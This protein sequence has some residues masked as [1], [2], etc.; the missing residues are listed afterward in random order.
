MPEITE[1]AAIPDSKLARAI[2]D[3]I[4]DTLNEP[5]EAEA[6]ASEESEA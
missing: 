5:V 6:A 1:A 4:R 2:A 3:Y